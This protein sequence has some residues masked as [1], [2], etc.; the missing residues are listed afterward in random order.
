MLEELRVPVEE[1]GVVDAAPAPRLL[2]QRGKVSGAAGGAPRGD[3]ELTPNVEPNAVARTLP[4][5][6]VV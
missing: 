4:R 6:N 1:E 5:C 3:K 2:E